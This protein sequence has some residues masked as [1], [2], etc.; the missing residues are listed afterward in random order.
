MTYR[1]F[2]EDLMMSEDYATPIRGANARFPCKNGIHCSCGGIADIARVVHITMKNGDTQYRLACLRCCEVC[3]Y[4]V[5]PKLLT[6]EEMALSVEVL[7]K[8]DDTPCARCG[9]V[10]GE[11]HHTSPNAIFPDAAAWPVIRLCRGCHMEWHA[12]VESFYRAR[13]GK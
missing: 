8:R 6:D 10:G 7:D 5:S 1:D 9:A 4:N 2:A 11:D 3:F 12:R 13:F